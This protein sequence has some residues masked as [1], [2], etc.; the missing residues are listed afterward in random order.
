[1]SRPGKGGRKKNQWD[2]K[3]TIRA[4]D[5]LLGDEDDPKEKN[6]ER[7]FLHF[8]RTLCRDL[9]ANMPAIVAFD[10]ILRLMRDKAVPIRRYA[11]EVNRNFAAYKPLAPVMNDLLRGGQVDELWKLWFFA[12]EMPKRVHVAMVNIDR[13]LYAAQEYMPVPFVVPGFQ[14]ATARAAVILGLRSYGYDADRIASV[15]DPMGHKQGATAARDRIRKEVRR[16]DLAIQ[17]GKADDQS[18][19]LVSTVLARPTQDNGT[20]GP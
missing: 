11:Q 2:L 10:Q 19:E 13:L 17:R 5:R 14:I 6:R 16:L 3:A 1:M 18:G 4:L 7:S 12:C 20:R 8:V 9:D 15:L